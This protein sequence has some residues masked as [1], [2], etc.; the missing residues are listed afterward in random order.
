[1]SADPDTVNTTARSDSPSVPEPPA[2]GERRARWG[3]GYQD[4]VATAQLLD[5]VRA[6]IRNGTSHFEGVRLADLQAGRVDDFVLVTDTAVQGN[7]IK[8]SASAPAM[9]W[10]DLIGADGLLR[11]LAEGWNR[12]TQSWRD[13]GVTVYLQTNRSASTDTHPAQ[14]VKTVSV[15]EFFGTY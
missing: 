5:L 4:K 8:W 13:R 12:L 14:L 6:D 10:G 3:Y 7:S 15:A 2:M 11:E 9:N 1:M